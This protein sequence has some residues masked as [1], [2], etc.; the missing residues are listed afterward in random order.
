MWKPLLVYNLYRN[1]KKKDK[2]EKAKIISDFVEFI[3]RYK[4]DFV[5][6]LS[7]YIYTTRRK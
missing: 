7:Y 1:V 6:P 3:D 5:V 2:E 4:G